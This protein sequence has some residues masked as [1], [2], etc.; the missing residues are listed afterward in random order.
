MTRSRKP[1][2]ALTIAADLAA[3]TTGLGAAPSTVDGRAAFERLK[4]LE[5][6]WVAPGTEGQR[7]TTTFKLTASGTVLV[8]HYTNPMLPGGGQMMTA[9]HLDGNALVLTH[10]CIADNQP[11]L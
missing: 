8:E 4:T 9:Y 3:L 2:Y 6:S 11:T 7:A 10:Y 1:F 5:G